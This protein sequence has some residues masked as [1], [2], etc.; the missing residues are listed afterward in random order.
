MQTQNRDFD[1]ETKKGGPSE[2]KE[3]EYPEK[4]IRYYQA[5]MNQKSLDGLPGLLVA[6]KSPLTSVV[7]ERLQP[8]AQ[9][10]MLSKVKNAQKEK[11]RR[12]SCESAGAGGASARTGV[13]HYLKGPEE[14]AY[15]LLAFILGLVVATYMPPAAKAI[16]S[17]LVKVLR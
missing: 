6:F 16:G 1:F 7:K 4:G 15:V 2:V 14:M 13:G 17:N 12:P 11:E 8:I 10:S 5:L 9:Q 3:D